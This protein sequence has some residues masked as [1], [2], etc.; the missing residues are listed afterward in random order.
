M[1]TTYETPHQLV[2]MLGLKCFAVYALMQWAEIEGLVPITR[3]WLIDNMPYATSPSTITDAL[4]FLTNDDKQFAVKVKGGWRLATGFQPAL[5]YNEMSSE[6]T[7]VLLDDDVIDITPRVPSITSLT[8]SGKQM[9]SERT[10]DKTSPEDKARQA[11]LR[12]AGIGRLSWPDLLA[13]EW[14]TVEYIQAH[15]EQIKSESDRWDNPVGMMITR[16]KNEQ[17]PAAARNKPIKEKVSLKCDGCG[18]YQCRCDDDDYQPRTITPETI[19][20][21]AQKNYKIVPG[22]CSACQTKKDV[23]SIKG[24]TLCIDH[25]N[26]WRYQQLGLDKWGVKQ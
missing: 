16:M 1:K 25:Y 10:F 11:A 2:R 13:C 9:S 6:R 24:A 15:A 26:E 20:T 21:L 8:S 19:E 3:N 22:I 4:R 18:Q 7:R 17:A 5:P 12:E 23:V 14:V